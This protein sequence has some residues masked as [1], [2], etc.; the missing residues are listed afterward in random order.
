MKII[1]TSVRFFAERNAK[2]GLLNSSSLRCNKKERKKKGNNAEKDFL[3][4]TAYD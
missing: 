1:D 4:I 2:F 3:V